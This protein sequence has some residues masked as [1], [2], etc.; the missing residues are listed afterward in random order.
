MRRIN[1]APRPGAAHLDAFLGTR[2]P[3]S[4][5]GV[6]DVYRETTICYAYMCAYA[7]G[8][9]EKTG[10]AARVLSRRC[11]RYQPASMRVTP[12]LSDFA[13]DL[14]AGRRER[15]EPLSP[16]AVDLLDRLRPDGPLRRQ[17]K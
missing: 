4:E 3:P 1:P 10:R 14:L 15:G 5:S 13:L 7:Y 2:L 12:G 9:T 17:A 11:M 16:D 8:C 6:L